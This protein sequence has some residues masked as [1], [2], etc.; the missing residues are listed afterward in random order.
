MKILLFVAL[1]IL[2]ICQYAL[3]YSLGDFERLLED[4]GTTLPTYSQWVFSISNSKVIWL[5][6]KFNFIIGVLFIVKEK[7][8]P[9]TMMILVAL[10]II[11]A[12][13]WAVYGP[14]LSGNAQVL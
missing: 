6:P 12:L 2:I 7:Y 13:L 8:L 4:F 11:G 1:L 9:A 3:I 14:M 10:M 5:L